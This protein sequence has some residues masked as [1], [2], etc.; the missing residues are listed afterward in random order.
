ME[1]KTTLQ[2]RQAAAKVAYDRMLAVIIGYSPCGKLTIEDAA[3]IARTAQTL[4]FDAC[5][6][7]A[8]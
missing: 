5:E 8:A 6:Q 7:A 2:R 1:P 3:Y 4:A